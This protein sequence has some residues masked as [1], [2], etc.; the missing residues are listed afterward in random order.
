M[1]RRPTADQPDVHSPRVCDHSPQSGPRSVSNGYLSGPLQSP[2]FL[3]F[4]AHTT[5]TDN[6]PHIFQHNTQTSPQGCP[7]SPT[8][9]HN[10]KILV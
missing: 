9:H 10:E 5:S 4:F 7:N 6:N 2:F 3:N 8:N 1:E